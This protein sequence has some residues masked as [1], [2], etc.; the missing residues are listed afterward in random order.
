MNTQLIIFTQDNVN[1]I[2]NNSSFDNANTTATAITGG[3]QI[4]EPSGASSSTT[5]LITGS[6]AL[7]FLGNTGYGNQSV[8]QQ[9]ACIFNQKYKLKYHISYNSH[10]NNA[11]NDDKLKLTGGGNNIVNADVTL[12]DDVGTHE[13][14]FICNVTNGLIEIRL[15]T[16]GANVTSPLGKTIIDYVMINP[17]GEK[18]TLDLYQDETIPLTYTINDVRELDSKKS[19]YSKDFDLPGTKKNNKYFNHIY[20]ITADTTFNPYRKARAILKQ[21]GT[22]IFDGNLQLMKIKKKPTGEII[23]TVSLFNESQ[24]FS[25]FLGNRKLHELPLSDLEHTLDFTTIMNSWNSAGASAVGSGTYGNTNPMGDKILYPMVYYQNTLSSLPANKFKI[26]DLNGTFRPWIKVKELVNRMFNESGYTYTSDFFNSDTFG[27][28]YMDLNFPTDESFYTALENDNVA[29]LYNTFGQNYNLYATHG[30]HTATWN[31]SA[32]GSGSGASP[33]LFYFNAYVNSFPTTTDF[34]YNDTTEVFTSNIDGLVTHCYGWFRCHTLYGGTI[35]A[36]LHHTSPYQQSPIVRT[37]TQGYTNT[38][39]HFDFHF[40]FGNL[41]LDDGDTVTLKFSGSGYPQ[42][43]N[44]GNER[45]VVDAGSGTALADKSKFYY[46]V[47]LSYIK[48]SEI[49]ENTKD[50]TQWEFFSSLIKMF[51]LVVEPDKDNP[52]NLKIEPYS[53]F[54]DSGEVRDWTSKI[55][56]S[57]DADIQMIG[58]VSKEVVLKYEPDPADTGQEEYIEQSDISEEYGSHK[59]ET[60]RDYYDNQEI[61]IDAG[62]FSA[63]V[64]ET[65]GGTN[66]VAMPKIM[67][68]NGENIQ[69][70]PR[71]LFNNGCHDLIAGG[72]WEYEIINSAGS[73]TVY[74][75]G[76]SGLT[77]AS[78]ILV[79]NHYADDYLSANLG[80]ADDLNFGNIQPYRFNPTNT[81]STPPN[82]PTNTLF[83]KYWRDYINLVF[84]SKS[85]LVIY[86]TFLTPADIQ[87]FSFADTIRIKGE[88]YRVNK[89]EYIAGSKNNKTKI[90]LLKIV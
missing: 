4:I 52:K 90:E 41:V 34:S 26:N 24:T 54:V 73:S 62:I 27:K 55:D 16:I 64:F 3:W 71:I 65:F 77:Q 78:K 23:Y 84:S 19:S 44:A 85:R 51:N 8:K 21:Q 33:T 53:D 32:G 59:Y 36:E 82:F 74:N 42:F 46:D 28:M 69:N 11:S 70:K 72:S 76:T 43:S 68:E 17:I 38:W 58:D 86:E 56:H 35:H 66:Q 80:S 15:D 5:P 18:D 31:S 13:Y 47:G 75:S 10:L 6:G 12:A 61:T 20:E 67:G 83:V 39:N 49:L 30:S 37:V 87:T 50:Y 22:V 9:T 14:E 89:L 79:F 88:T 1:V 57:V 25:E 63:T 81:F 45:T 40:D 7:Q 29:I 2:P 60:D 48:P